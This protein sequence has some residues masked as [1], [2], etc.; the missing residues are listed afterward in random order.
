M[1]WNL[2]LGLMSPTKKF[3]E[4]YTPSK[5]RINFRFLQAED[6][7]LLIDFYHRLSPATRYMRFQFPTES[8]PEEKIREYAERF[9]HTDPEREVAL[10]ALHREEVVGVIRYVK[11]RVED[12]NAEFALV[13]RDDFQKKRLG[14]H[15]MNLL[16]VVA[17]K[18]RLRYLYGNSV[19]TNQGMIR[20]VKRASAN[21]YEIR[22]EG[23]SMYLQLNL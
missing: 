15:L 8:L 10:L 9:A 18:N 21:S 13:I 1:F 3:K 20:L 12:D 17:R 4:F 23:G 2:L 19:S 11:E 14:L 16:I 5:E 6:L 7:E 22:H